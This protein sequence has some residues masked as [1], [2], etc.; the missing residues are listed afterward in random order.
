MQLQAIER[1]MQAL[2]GGDLVHAKSI[3]EGLA[4]AGCR[5]ADFHH[6]A[7]L[8]AARS[9]DAVGAERAFR[10]A[11]QVAPG[12]PLARMNFA[13]WL[14]SRSD[15]DGALA[16]LCRAVAEAPS[17]D[18]AWLE[19]GALRLARGEPQ[20]A[21]A[22][23]ERVVEMD[24]GAVRAWLLLGSAW[25]ALDELS[26]AEDALL[27]V[28]ALDPQH[29]GARVALAMVL[30]L[31]GRADDA[32]ASLQTLAGSDDPDVL[33]TYAGALLDTGDVAG[34]LSTVDRLVERFP[35]FVPGY[36]TYAHLHS[37]YGSPETCAADA[38][39]PLRAAVHARPL[40]EPLRAE[41]ARLLHITGDAE[42]GLAELRRLDARHEQ[43]GLI[44]LEADM[45]DALGRT[46]EAGAVFE[47]A[48]RQRNAND[49]ELLKGQ[50]RHL[51]RAGAPDRAAVSAERATRIAPHD[52]EAWAYLGTAW[53]L[54][55]DARGAWLCDYERL[56][57]VVDV[58]C[59]PGDGDLHAFMAEAAQAMERLHRARR[60][61]LT[62]S[63]RGG[64]QTPGRLF[65]RRDPVI[66]ALHE[67]V[68]HAVED[69][70]GGL[71]SDPTHPFLQRNTRQARITGSWSVRLQSSGRHE[72][73]MHPQ[74][75]LSSAFYLS[76]PH[77]VAEDDP[78]AAGWLQFGAPP[79]EL[80]VA[81][82]PA[83][84]VC[85]R[86]GRLVLFPSFFW[87]GTV[88]FDA[89]APRITV[90]FDAVPGPASQG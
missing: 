31:S 3:V 85:P 14:R 33:D 58:P 8:C 61:P 35:E 74:G 82:P 36:A 47:H 66:R 88:P 60:A 25:R 21:I 79:T 57:G 71:P 26:R 68:S 53:Q 42:A 29:R 18:R 43:V 41:Y 73:H 17:L 55:G 39:A 16:H 72:N 32:V 90:A 89:D 37:E 7:A 11:L 27:K 52:Q 51:L 86:V 78:Q 62:Q 44:R 54:T 22:P 6:L 50:A 49:V 48:Q 87:H 34:A 84:R 83:H 24:P 1:G 67:A 65:G 69:W 40:H 77:V 80:G 5:A 75:W 30:R 9:G 59:P 64:S 2:Q 20:A 12:H 45:L 56:V 23:L 19:L 10:A 38:L 28:L 4:R 76:L 63:V 13:A 70:I 46:V 15:L 81:L